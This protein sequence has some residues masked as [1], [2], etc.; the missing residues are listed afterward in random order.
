MRHSFILF[1]ALALFVLPIGPVFAGDP[2]VS[3][4]T[5]QCGDWN[6]GFNWSNMDEYKRSVSHGNSETGGVKVSTDTLVM[7]SAADPE[8]MMKIAIMKYTS[9]DSSP[10]NSSI[11]MVRAD[12]AL[13]KSGS[14]NRLSS[15]AGTID[16]RPAAFVSG[17]RCQD[18]RPVYIAVYPVSHYF[19]RSGHTLESDALGVIVSTYDSEITERLMS[20]IKIEQ[21]N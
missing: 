14:C 1:I 21:S 18:E 3:F 4:V 17:S 9:R 20:S 5:E 15:A 2:G 11:L 8:I 6:V 16:G 7:T 13:S 19:D 10:V 12:E